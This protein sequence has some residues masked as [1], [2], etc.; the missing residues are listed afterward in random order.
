MSD[1]TWDVISNRRRA[2]RD[3]VL[4]K[5]R[6]AYKNNIDFL[7]LPTPTFPLSVAAQTALV[8]QVAALTRQNRDIIRVLVPDL[9]D[10]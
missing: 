6:A 5:A 7:T 8:A 9:L 3:D 2:A 4:D 10:P 1:E